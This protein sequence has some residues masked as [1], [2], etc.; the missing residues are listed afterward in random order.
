MTVLAWSDQLSTAPAVEPVSVAEARRNSDVDDNYRD[1]DF[2]RWIV[3][4]RQ[5]VEHDARLYL[6]NQAR[7]RTLDTFPSDSYIPLGRPLVSVTSFQYV[8]ANGD[9]Q[10][11]ATSNYEVDTKRNCVHLAYNQSWPTIREKPNAITITYVAG[12]GTTQTDVPPAAKAAVLM[13][14]R[15]RHDEPTDGM[16]KGWDE[17]IY[18]LKGG[19]YP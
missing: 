16:P 4:A 9:T 6:I 14:V 11:W 17:L 12:H 3:E 19:V 13:H 10:T 1:T 7:V 18:Q 2:S 8:D 15:T 5:R